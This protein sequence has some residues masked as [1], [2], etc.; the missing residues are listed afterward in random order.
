MYY[1]ISGAQYTLDSSP[2]KSGGEGN[3]YAILGNQSKFAKIYHPNVLDSEL[4][5][6]LCTM[7]RNP[8]AQ[9]VLTQIAWPVDVLYD[10]RRQFCGFLM[11][12]L[13]T[14]HELGEIY[15]YPP[16]ELAGVTLAHKLIIAQN[17]CSVISA[18][19]SAGYV[20]GDFNPM[21]IGVNIN[22]GTVAFFDA[23]TYHFKDI[24]SG[25]THRCRACCPG[26]VAPELIANCKRFSAAHPEVKDVYANAP[27]PTFSLETDN[28]ALSIH[29]FNLIMNGYTPYNGIPENSPVSQAS[30]GVGDRAVERN[31]YCFSPGNKPM[32]AAMPE[33]SSLPKYIQTLFSRSFI[34]GYATP[35][36]RPSADE[37]IIA[38]SQFEQDLTQCRLN[39][40]HFY[41]K[42]H[43][44]CPYCAAD[45]RYE[46][47]L[48]GVRSTNS[49]ATGQKKFA[50][51]PVIGQP[52]MPTHTSR[53][54][55][56]VGHSTT[57]HATTQSNAA[58]SGSSSSKS[59]SKGLTI[60]VCAIIAVIAIVFVSFMSKVDRDTIEIL[61]DDLTL[62]VGETV[63]IRIR[64]SAHR[65]TANS[66][67]CIETSWNNGKASGDKYYVDVTGLE[68]G[69][70][71]LKIY[72]TDNSE[73]YDTVRIDVIA[74]D[75]QQESAGSLNDD[76]QQQIIPKNTLEISSPTD[77]DYAIDGIFVG[78]TL[79]ISEE[80][81]V[82]YDGYLSEDDARDTFTYT[83]P[84][85]GRY[86][87]EISDISANDGVRLM[88][89]DPSGSKL[90]DS[91]SESGYVS[92][93]GGTTYEI[94]VRQENGYP[95]YNLALYI[96]KPTTDLSYT[97]TLY[98]QIAFTNQR[99]NYVFTAPVTGRYH[100]EMSEYMS[101][102]GF[103]MM[104]W[105][106][107]DS[108]IMDTYYEYGT[109]SLDAGETYEL[110]IRQDSG[111]SS[112]KLQIG[113]QKETFDLTGYT[114]IFDS[115]EY[116]GQRNVY[117]F[118]AP[119]SGR[120]R[121]EMSEYMSGTGF[122]MM[123]WDKYD[124][125][126][127]DT[128]YEYGTVS[129]DA[130]ETYELQIRQDSDYSSYKLKIGMQKETVD[131]SNYDIISDSVTFTDQRNV[132]TFT[133][134]ESGKYKFTLTDF[135]A[136]CSF[137]LM[138]W[139]NYDSTIMDTYYEEGTVSLE[140]GITYEI[141][142]RQDSSIGS[143]NLNI[144]KE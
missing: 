4:E 100:F 114:T 71:N 102:V 11:N 27:L 29:I 75:E 10:S 96:Q 58:Y 125:N 6:K 73:I 47:E 69:V 65:L 45:Q 97:T 129:L 85:D 42:K 36:A 30:P 109:V 101:G 132:Y 134:D 123:M 38:L 127:M 107:Y 22:D 115:I 12:K 70:C 25:H 3:I 76:G 1:G 119:I 26:Y 21:N 82:F 93:T 95:M 44:V 67:D 120:Y 131:I 59:G 51:A 105:D 48:S 35:T 113:F 128:Y 14:T 108:N 37:W 43:P 80:P 33:Y 143:Y 121:F 118:T 28:F 112:Y 126:I 55:T 92:M 91:Y 99:N 117:T 49:I 34:D 130:G 5:A 137:R 16:N 86:Q 7:Y 78:E 138:A 74:S 77:N 52:V 136:D 24:A 88:V 17:I 54:S 64:S 15:K 63:E 41:Y 110:Q 87:L 89:F 53:Q 19:H 13:N 8:P 122:R 2:I 62:A 66:N 135:N 90:L 40:N 68:E 141:Q 72:K 124:S 94:Q 79:A 83:A 116:T 139:D 32:A 140:S 46:N 39:T 56:S 50:S 144:E 104:M 18:V 133:P 20:F 23:D 84:R 31:N 81:V 106:K 9:E 142:V 103:R 61:N 57:T 60:F 98:D 111:I